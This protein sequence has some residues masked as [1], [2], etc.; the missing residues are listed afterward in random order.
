MKI[1]DFS[2]EAKKRNIV[3]KA[4]EKVVKI[5]KEEVEETV[6]EGDFI[7]RD[8]RVRIRVEPDNGKVLFNIFDIQT[9]T[10]YLDYTFDDHTWFLISEASR[11][12][13]KQLDGAQDED[14]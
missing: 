9:N 5:F 11:L 4:P 14:R 12:M 8:D 7:H 10:E 3:L 13:F 2:K 1:I 6:Y